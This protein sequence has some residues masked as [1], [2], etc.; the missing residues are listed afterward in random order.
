MKFGFRVD[1]MTYRWE[2][3]GLMVGFIPFRWFSGS[4]VAFLPTTIARAAW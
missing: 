4:I 3:Y 1:M 2:K